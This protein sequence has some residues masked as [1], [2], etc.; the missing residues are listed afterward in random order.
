MLLGAE[1]FTSAA[2]DLMISVKANP[3]DAVAVDGLLLRGRPCLQT[4]RG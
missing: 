1:S 2:T 4:G 3:D